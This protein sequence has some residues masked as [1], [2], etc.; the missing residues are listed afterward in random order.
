MKSMN[1]KLILLVAALLT[2]LVTLVA[3]NKT[4]DPGEETQ[5]AV[6]T[7]APSETDTVAQPEETSATVETDAVTDALT[8]PETEPVTEAPTSEPLSEEAA[9]EAFMNAIV[10]TN[11]AT[12]YQMS[13]D[14]SMSMMGMD[15]GTQKMTQVKS[16]DDAMFSQESDGMIVTA[17]IVGNTVYMATTV[18]GESSYETFT[19]DEI[20]RAWIMQQFASDSSESD[21]EFAPDSFSGLSGSKA[22]DGTVTLTATGFSE[23]IK[24]AFMES[25]AD[26]PMDMLME[27]KSCVLT[28]NP[29][30]L[31]S[32]M[33]LT[34]ELSGEMEDEG[35]S[36]NFSAA[37]TIAVTASY[38]NIV[39][40]APENAAEYAQTTFESYYMMVPDAE[41]AAAG[42]LP[43]DQDSYVIGAEGSTVTPD[44]QFMLLATC[45][46][47]YEGKTFTI[48]G[49]VG[50]NE[51]LGVPVIY[52]GEYGTFYFYCPNGV[53][54]PV[55][56]DSV[57]ITATF[58]NTADKGY[59][60][61]YL[62]YTM[63]VSQC[64]VVA[65]GVGPNG[66]RIMFIT[67]SS[68]NVR[69][70]SDTSS[71]DN[72]I[73]TLSQGDAVEVFDQDDKGWWRI[74]FNGQTAYISNKYVSETRP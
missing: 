42:G 31:I 39:V 50:E 43:L 15:M 74:E 41:D 19:V 20:Q 29:Q 69:T 53:V 5:G 1:K 73:G 10:A 52:A 12:D 40:A 48:Y 27:L 63:M 59:D 13:M 54:A 9:L 8:E 38:E 17:V 45:F 51:E 58:E 16:G 33:S 25:M 67:A 57:K 23:E 66:G 72:I 22:Q 62:C 49:T 7:A 2:V 3:C 18:E 14:M 32:G 24:A 21:M 4:N 28:I 65:H 46:R 36:A 6:D 11:A 34:L 30:G 71:S 37:M 60:S 61:D 35:V 55:F 47:A 70:S 64:E 26:L 56:G 68:L 44:D